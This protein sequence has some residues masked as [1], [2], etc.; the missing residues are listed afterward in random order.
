MRFKH[1]SFPSATRNSNVNQWLGNVAI[2]KVTVLLVLQKLTQQQFKC[3]QDKTSIKQFH[4]LKG[5]GKRYHST[6][7]STVSEC[8][9]LLK[10]A[11]RHKINCHFK[12]A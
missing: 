4:L 12:N 9:R 5:P 7:C 2:R 11:K 8:G 6:V 10:D 3:F 1:P